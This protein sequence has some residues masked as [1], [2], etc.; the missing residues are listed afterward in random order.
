LYISEFIRNN[1]EY[2]NLDQ[3]FRNQ[4]L[5]EKFII[6]YISEFDWDTICERQK[7]SEEFITKYKYKV[8]W[9]YISWRQNLSLQFIKDNIDNLS[10]NN[11]LENEN[12]SEDIKEYIKILL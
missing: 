4:K 9:E 11:L 2:L 1:I 5:S 8:D 10:L 7:L 6:E 12:I 3:I